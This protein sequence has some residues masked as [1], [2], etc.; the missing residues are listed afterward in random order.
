MSSDDLTYSS[1]LRIGELLDLQTCRSVDPDTGAPEH[2]E[3]LFIV[4]GKVKFYH[5][6]M[7][8]VIADISGQEILTADKAVLRVNFY[9]HFRITD[10]KRAL[11]DNKNYQNQIEN[12]AAATI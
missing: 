11:M 9:V 12:P 4:T 7:R 6:D 8:E 1:Y 5:V 10:I 3:T 2:D